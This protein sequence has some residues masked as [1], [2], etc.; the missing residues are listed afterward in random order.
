VAAPARGSGE[1]GVGRP[2]KTLALGSGPMRKD[3]IS[4]VRQAAC[5]GPSLWP[6]NIYRSG[7]QRNSVYFHFEFSHEL[8]PTRISHMIFIK[9]RVLDFNR[10][11][12]ISYF[13]K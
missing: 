5:F 3:G 2:Y 11:N 7:L 4:N 1:A 6:I 8:F 9:Q 10:T 13:L 12:T